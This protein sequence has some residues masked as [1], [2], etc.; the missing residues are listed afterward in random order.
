MS[1]IFNFKFKLFFLKSGDVH[2]TL[3]VKVLKSL[4]FV[5]C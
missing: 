4:E 3:K 5:K 2:F 1:G